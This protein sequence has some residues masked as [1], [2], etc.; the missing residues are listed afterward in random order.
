MTQ[1]QLELMQVEQ[2]IQRTAEQIERHE[3]ILKI[4]RS[5]NIARHREVAR[6]QAYAERDHQKDQ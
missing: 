2:A 5:K 6:Q 1:R 3:L 4:L